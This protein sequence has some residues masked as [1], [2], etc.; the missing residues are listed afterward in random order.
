MVREKDEEW[1]KRGR[2]RGM[3]GRR[4]KVEEKQIGKNDS[5]DRNINKEM[6]KE[7]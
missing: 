4:E 1:K 7:T 2:R 5:A 6:K 3:E